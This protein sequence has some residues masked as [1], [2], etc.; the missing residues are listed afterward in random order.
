MNF[1]SPSGSFEPDSLVPAW[2]HAHNGDGGAA[3]DMSIGQGYS[4]YSTENMKVTF[5]GQ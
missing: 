5:S 1:L 2:Y 4:F 3:V